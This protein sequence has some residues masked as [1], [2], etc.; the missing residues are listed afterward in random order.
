MPP[1]SCLTPGFPSICLLGLLPTV[2]SGCRSWRE[3]EQFQ[4]HWCENRE[5]NQ[6]GFRKWLV[7][8]CLVCYGQGEHSA[9]LGLP[10]LSDH[11][12]THTK[13][14]SLLVSRIAACCHSLVESIAACGWSHITTWPKVRGWLCVTET[15]ERQMDAH[16][17]SMPCKRWWSP[18]L[19]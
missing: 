11:I 13:S 17:R 4:G 6:R 3:T 9:T 15:E 2:P 16:L 8:S 1:R 10:G 14:L 18:T 5:F 12:N 19:T 7:L